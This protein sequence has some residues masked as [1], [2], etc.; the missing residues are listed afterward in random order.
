SSPSE[1][2]LIETDVTSEQS[3][4][5]AF[6]KAVS[7]YRA[8]DAVIHTVGMWSMAPIAETTFENWNTHLNLNLSSAFLIFRQAIRE[9][10]GQGSLIGI[11]SRQGVV[12]GAS[13]QAGYSASKGGLV[14]LAEA[15]AEEYR[16]S[17]LHAHIVA[18]STIL[19]EDGQTGG[20]KVQDLVAHCLYLASDKGRSLSGTV[21]SAFGNG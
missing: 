3:V 15:I 14:R 16:D 21:L 11:S 7:L 17:G 18:P 12:K 9:M 1:W 2:P 6:E 4:T 10:N 13:E 20:V 19:F 5:G 8:P